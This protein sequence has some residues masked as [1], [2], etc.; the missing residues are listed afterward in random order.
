[1]IVFADYAGARFLQAG[2]SSS[3]A[4]TSAS[5]WPKL[6]KSVRFRPMSASVSTPDVPGRTR[7]D[8]AEPF[9]QTDEVN[10]V[11]V[12]AAPTADPSVRWRT[13]AQSGGVELAVTFPPFAFARRRSR[14]ERP[15]RAALLAGLRGLRRNG[16]HAVPAREIAVD[17]IRLTNW[18]QC[19]PPHLPSELPLQSHHHAGQVRRKGM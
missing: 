15:E 1:M 4:R 3:S 9:V 10:R 7:E 12:L 18:G 16:M 11:I 13:T 5:Y 8:A 17:A 19:I 2:L 6:R 14:P